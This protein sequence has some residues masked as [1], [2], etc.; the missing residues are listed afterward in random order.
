MLVCALIL[1]IL[2]SIVGSNG[3]SIL[4]VVPSPS[5]SHQVVFQP[6]WK[7]LSLRGHQVT[8]ITTDPINDR[9]LTNLTEIDLH[10]IYEEWN[11]LKLQMMEELKRSNWK[12]F[13]LLFRL[14][15]SISDN[16]LHNQAVQSLIRDQNQNFDLVFVEF[17]APILFAFG[18][19]FKCPV[20]AVISLDGTN[21]LH[22]L[23]GD[24]T[25]PVLYPSAGYPF[26][27]KLNF[28]ERF[29]SCMLNFLN[30]MFFEY[31]K[32]EMQSVLNKHFGESSSSLDDLM[33]RIDMAFINTDSIL[34]PIRP[35]VPA[36]I[37]IGTGIHLKPQKALPKVIL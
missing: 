14:M 28:V 27:A 29:M 21:P 10:Y 23:M 31:T 8:T 36:V 11:E 37:Q 1:V 24:P 18:E 19:R 17:G 25:H 13:L 34:H 12:L 22:N 2:Q 26:I 4:A 32:P 15:T 6:I 3:A 9:T 5:Y 16:L 33:E 7:E 35:L 20:I 30:D